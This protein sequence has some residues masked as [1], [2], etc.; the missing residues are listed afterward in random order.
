VIGSMLLWLAVLASGVHPTVAGVVA[1][2]T[3]PLVRSPGAPDAQGSMLHQLEARIAPWSAFGIVPLFGFFNAGVALDGVGLSDLAAPLPMGIALGLFAGK[4]VGILASVW[5]A[6]RFGVAAPLKGVGPQQLWGVAA[7]CGIG[8]T[9][10]LFIGALAFPGDPARVEEA[11]LGILLGSLV[12]ALAG[13]VLLRFAP[14]PAAK[15]RGK[16]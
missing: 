11:K 8:F 6:V 10:S 16:G 1:A 5:L 2:S 3:I 12:S 14:L 13:Y 7:L 15:S 9:M 4:Q